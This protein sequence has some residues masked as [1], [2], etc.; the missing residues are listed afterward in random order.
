MRSSFLI[1]LAAGIM[2][3]T[4]AAT[5]LD[6]GTDLLVP[7]AARAG[8]WVTDLY[9]FN[10]GSETAS[11]SISWLVRGQANTETTTADYTLAPGAQLVSEDIIL[12]VFGLANAGG[13]LRVQSDQEVAVTSRI[14]NLRDGVS[15]G[16]G[17]EGIPRSRA[18]AAGGSADILGLSNNDHFRTN[19][20]VIDTSGTGATVALSLRDSDGVEIASRVFQLQAFEPLLYPITE[21]DGVTTFD[22]GTLHAEVSYGAAIVVASKIDNDPAT[23]DPTTLTAWS[24]A[25]GDTDGT[26]Q[27]VI[28][29]ASGYASGGNLVIADGQ[30]TE[31]SATYV[32]LDKGSPDDPDCP[33]SF[34][35]GSPEAGVATLDQYAEG[36]SFVSRSYLAGGT[37]SWTVQLVVSNNHTLSGTIDAEGSGFTGSISGCNGSF[38]TL[39]LRGGK[40]D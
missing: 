28:Y 24:G 35:W 16:Q 39:Q 31:I 20:I 37:I 18:L 34:L 17:F 27:I 32:N 21:L 4:S 36:H 40:F 14:Y 6:G 8:A 5:A 11:L 25:R 1:L 33:L 7:A 3:I 22:H 19:M 29:E 26:Y 23:G 38:P 2:A 9:V 10:P 15:F 13:A 30:V 12:E